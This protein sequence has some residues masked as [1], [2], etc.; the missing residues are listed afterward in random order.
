MSDDEDIKDFLGPTIVMTTAQKDKYVK[1]IRAVHHEAF[2]L[3]ADTGALATIMITIGEGPDKDHPAAVQ[4]AIIYE[5]PSPYTQE[6]MGDII[7]TAMTAGAM[8]MLDAQKK[9]RH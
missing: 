3:I 6:E 8:M 1:E 7:R 5:N 4:Q 2:D 9:P